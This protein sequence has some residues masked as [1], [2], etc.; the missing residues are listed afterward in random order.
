M[1]KE[2]G[3]YL[4]QEYDTYQDFLNSDFLA[5]NE[6]FLEISHMDLV[7]YDGKRDLRPV[8]ETEV[9]TDLD[10]NLDGN[11]ETEGMLDPIENHIDSDVRSITFTTVEDGTLTFTRNDK[12]TWDSEDGSYE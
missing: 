1:E 10:A 6:K 2:G 8:V 9:E 7:H 4:K 3:K 5:K 11:V 12:E